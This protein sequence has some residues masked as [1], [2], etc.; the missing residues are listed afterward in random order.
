MKK[1]PTANATLLFA[2]AIALAFSAGPPSALAAPIANPQVITNVDYVVLDRG[3]HHR[4]WAKVERFRD[5]VTGDI[6][7]R[8][9]IAYIELATGM[10][11]ADPQTGQW[12]E[13]RELIEPIPGGAI[14]HFGQHVLVFSNDLATAG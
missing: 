5:P 1:L 10:H 12:R 13:T 6:L 11:Y 9:N 8:T 7:A 4:Q 2:S 14:A 3:L